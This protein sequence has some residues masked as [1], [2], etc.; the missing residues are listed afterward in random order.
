LDEHREVCGEPPW[1]PLA[2][3]EPEEERIVSPTPRAPGCRFIMLERSR[4]LEVLRPR[5]DKR[6]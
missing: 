5:C 3:A 6:E 2:R 1:P 4:W